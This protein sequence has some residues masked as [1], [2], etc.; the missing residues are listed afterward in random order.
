MTLPSG[1]TFADLGSWVLIVIGAAMALFGLGI[2]RGALTIFGSFVGGLF[3]LLMYMS[4][5]ESL[6]P[7]GGAGPFIF[8]LLFPLI[9]GMIGGVLARGFHYVAFFLLGCVM[10]YAA[11]LLFSGQ[12]SWGQ[13]QDPAAMAKVTGPHGWHWLVMVVVGLIYLVAS[14]WMIAITCAFLGASLIAG[15]LKSPVIL[16]LGAAVGT[17]VQWVLFLRNYVPERTVV[18]R[19][20]RRDPDER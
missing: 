10:G 11:I 1:Q 15:V 14:N 16:Y 18:R 17:F 7:F 5:R 13:I 8:G 3:G 9:G 20:V 12:L 6:P 4:N 2:Y 19:I